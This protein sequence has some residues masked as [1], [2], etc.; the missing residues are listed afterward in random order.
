MDGCEQGG[1]GGAGG[2]SADA[3]DV[4]IAVVAVG[5]IQNPA[6]LTD[7]SVK[8]ADLFDRIVD[9]GVLGEHAQSVEVG[10]GSSHRCTGVVDAGEVGEQVEPGDSAGVLN[11][12]IVVN[13]AMEAAVTTDRGNAGDVIVSVDAHTLSEGVPGECTDPSLRSAVERPNDC[14]GCV[15]RIED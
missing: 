2:I 3:D 4:A 7:Q 10:H 9:G 15:I 5:H 1:M 14:I 6:R 11:I 8:I 13:E 12:S